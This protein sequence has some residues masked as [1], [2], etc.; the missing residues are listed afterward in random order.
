MHQIWGP[1]ER[2]PGAPSDE[3]S[4]NSTAEDH[5]RMGINCP[6]GTL[7]ADINAKL[8]GVTVHKA[9]SSPAS[10]QS[11]AKKSPQAAPQ[12]RLQEFLQGNAPC[13]MVPEQGQGGSEDDEEED[14]D[15]NSDDSQGEGGANAGPPS[16]KYVGLDVRSPTQSVGSELHGV[17]ECAPCAWYWKTVGC[18]GGASCKFCHMCGPGVFQ[19]KTAIRRAE[20]VAE[21]R[22]LQ[23]KN[24]GRAGRNNRHRRDP[25]NR[26]AE[27]VEPAESA[28]VN[29]AGLAPMSLPAGSL[30]L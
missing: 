16:S 15:L 19:L 2:R 10:E 5:I 24:R 14:S 3:A 7:T 26:N 23:R 20:R 17:G 30:S 12:H 13:S 6:P 28:A 8:S 22:A 9:S 27:Q 29:L 25:A 11:P 4:S 18:T 1:I 21:L